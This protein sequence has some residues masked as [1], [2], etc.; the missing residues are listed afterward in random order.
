MGTQTLEVCENCGQNIGKLETPRLHEEHIVCPGCWQKLNQESMAIV[1]DDP[2]PRAIQQ[3]SVGL[4][5]SVYVQ[6]AAPP[7]PMYAPAPAIINNV[8]QQTTVVNGRTKRWSPLMAAI[9]SLFI[10]GLGQMYKG[11]IINGLV[12]FCVVAVGYAFL[13]LPG[14]VLHVLCVLGAMLGDP[15]R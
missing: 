10:P 12:W 3:P 6:V 11:Q 8:V 14:V 7:M 9:L 13:V 5:P 1:L 4:P 15:Y 2:S